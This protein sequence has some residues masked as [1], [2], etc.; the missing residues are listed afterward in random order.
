MS[1]FWRAY[2]IE[3]ETYSWALLL[4]SILLQIQYIIK[5]I[6]IQELIFYHM[7]R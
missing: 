3:R 7:R 6:D 4:S 1:V 2:K 5:K